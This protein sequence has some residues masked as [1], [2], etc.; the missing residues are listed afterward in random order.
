MKF[1]CLAHICLG[2]CLSAASGIF[3]QSDSADS[4]DSPILMGPYLGQPLPGKTPQRFAPDI[5]PANFQIH[6][7]PAFSPDGHE[8]YIS[9]F[10]GRR[11]SETIFCS[12]LEDGQWTPLQV[13][14]FSGIYFEG[15]PSFTPDGEKLFYGSHRPYGNG[16][17]NKQDRDIWYTERKD[18]RWGEPIPFEFNTTDWDERV[19]FAN[20]GNMYF[21]SGNDIYVSLFGSGYYADP[22]RLGTSINTDE[23][24]ELGPCVAAD[25]SYLIFC[26]SRPGGYGRSDLYISFKDNNGDWSEAKNMGPEINWVDGEIIGT[27]FA[28]LSPDGR[29]LFFTKIY[30]G[31]DDIYWV[32][33]AVIDELRPPGLK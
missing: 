4:G 30:G 6:S 19:S 17:T 7:S 9:F 1:R 22:E 8:V 20:N 13:A 26:S 29:Y 21:K 33:A 31:R 10:L 12:R 23:H 16:G 2:V 25:E 5:F 32:N 15:G 11:F 14:D 27:R 28:R 3:A 18:G 24:G